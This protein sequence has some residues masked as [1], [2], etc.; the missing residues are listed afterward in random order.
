[1]SGEMPQSEDCLYLNVVTPAKDPDEKLPVLVW[2][3]GGGYTMD[4]G[5][6]IIWNNYRLPLHG[7]PS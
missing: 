2:M 7:A 3:H 1:M 6:D 4:C 5:N